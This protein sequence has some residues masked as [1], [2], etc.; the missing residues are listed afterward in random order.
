[1]RVGKSI[2]KMLNGDNRDAVSS[3]TTDNHRPTTA[4]RLVSLDAFRGATVAAML[5]VNN[6][7]THWKGVMKGVSMKGVIA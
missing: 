4:N 5:L 7:D 2:P 1:M 6:P 3:P